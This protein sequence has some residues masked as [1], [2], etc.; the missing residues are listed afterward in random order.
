MRYFDDNIDPNDGGPLVTDDMRYKA[1]LIMQLRRSV[2]DTRVLGAMETV[3]RDQFVADGFHDQ[4]WVDQALPIGEAQTISQP[5]IVAR[6]TEA[7]DLTGRESVL[8]IGTGS[9]Y[10]AAILSRLA[11]RVYSV[12]R[13]ESLG[14]QAQE[15]FTRLKYHNITTRIGDG[16]LGWPEVAPFERIIVTAA[17][18]GDPPS[19]LL[20][21]LAPGGI[22]VIP[23]G[24]S[25]VDQELVKITR[26]LDGSLDWQEICPV[27]FVP[28]VAGEIK[29]TG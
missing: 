19:R 17:G 16:T 8:E 28:L 5:T 23:L 18:E 20:E 4:A 3:P 26:G 27:R 7:L 13:I 15:R 22:M 24:L 2:R 14:R 29:R 9:G 25:P 10:Q 6:M 12:E 21:Q 11:R 1:R